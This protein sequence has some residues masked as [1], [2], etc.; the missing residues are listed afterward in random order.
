MGAGQ[1]GEGGRPG[2]A[3]ED[4]GRNSS[5]RLPACH[6]RVVSDVGGAEGSADRHGPRVDVGQVTADGLAQQLP[7]GGLG[8]LDLNEW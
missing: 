1:H 6:R 3:D 2:G 5:A 4:I 8:I 7:H